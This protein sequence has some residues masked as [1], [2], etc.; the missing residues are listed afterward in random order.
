MN[1]RQTVDLFA[2][3]F[4]TVFPLGLSLS[5]NKLVKLTFL[6]SLWDL[7]EVLLSAKLSTKKQYQLNC[8]YSSVL[9]FALALARKLFYEGVSE[10]GKKLFWRTFQ[11]IQSWLY[12]ISP[13]TFLFVFQDQTLK[14]SFFWTKFSTLS[15]SSSGSG[16]EQQSSPTA[17]TYGQFSRT[18]SL[19]VCACA[20]VLM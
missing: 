19:C 17:E 2:K 1:I 13:F 20:G 8:L 7:R 14:V 18:Q 5:E 12:A 16:S 10:E 11:I 9:P 4:H 3:H 6:I 15:S